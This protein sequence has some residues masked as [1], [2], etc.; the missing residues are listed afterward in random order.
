MI[1]APDT[2]KTARTCNLLSNEEEYEEQVDVDII[3]I[4][5]KNPTLV[6]LSETVKEDCFFHG[7]YS[8]LQLLAKTLN[9]NVIVGAKRYVFKVTKSWSTD[10]YLEELAEQVTL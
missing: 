1:S 9:C 3:A 7:R 2:S 8:G 4:E 10:A 5:G 6:D